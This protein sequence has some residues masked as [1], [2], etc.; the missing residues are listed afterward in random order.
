MGSPVSKLPRYHHFEEVIDP[1]GFDREANDDDQRA[2]RKF[3][4]RYF[5]YGVGPTMTLK[6]C[7]FTNTPDR[8]FIIDTH[9]NMKNLVVVSPCSGHGF[10]FVSVIGEIAADLAVSYGSTRHNISLFQLSRFY[11]PVYMASIPQTHRAIG[12]SKHG[13]GQGGTQRSHTSGYPTPPG[14]RGAQQTSNLRSPGSNTTPT[15]SQ[16][17]SP[18]RRRNGAI[19]CR[20][21]S[22]RFGNRR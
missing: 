13:R 2:L 3:C 20:R 16:G 21:I 1:D 8:H 19:S 6:S 7:I 22:I 11:D 5:P 18:R 4:E 17:V 10:K 12:G 15:F 14:A 9:P